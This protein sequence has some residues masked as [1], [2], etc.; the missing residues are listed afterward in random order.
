MAHDPHDP[1]ADPE[2]AAEVEPPPPAG[3]APATFS[4]VL[5]EE[6]ILIGA[7]R[8]V[9]EHVEARSAVPRAGEPNLGG[10]DGRGLDRTTDAPPDED[11]L[12]KAARVRSL[13]SHTAGLAFSGGGIRSATFAVGFL[14][15]LASLG[16]I[17]RF[18]YLST[19]SG[20]GYA[21]SWLAAWLKRE[22]GGPQ[23]VEAQ[24]DP[25][26][27]AQARSHRRLVDGQVVDEEPEPL[28]HLRAFSSYLT[29]NPGLLSTDTW[30]VAL[31]WVR[32]VAV[33]MMMIL[34]WLFGNALFVRLLVY[35][36][37]LYN[38]AEP[39][40]DWLVALVSE[41]MLAAGLVLFF[42]GIWMNARALQEFRSDGAPAAAAAPAGGRWV[43][44]RSPVNA[45]IAVLLLLAAFGVTVPL[46]FVVWRL[47]LWLDARLGAS[48]AGPDGLRPWLQEV[49]GGV[50]LVRDVVLTVFDSVGSHLGLLQWPNLALHVL[51][52]GVLLYVGA[53][54]LAR[55]RSDRGVF[56]RAA[57]AAGATGGVLL[58]LLEVMT[59][60]FARLERPD[61]MATF[62]PPAA[63]LVVVAAIVVEVALLGRAITEAERE[64]WARVSARVAMQAV[65]W[66]VFSAT[67]LYV[68]ALLLHAGSSVRAAIASGWIG[69]AVFGVVTGRYVLPRLQEG[70]GLNITR[71][72]AAA[73]SAVF[74]IGLF[75]AVALA[76]SFLIDSPSP[77]DPR[78]ED[79]SPFALYLA[80][81]R[82]APLWA[83]AAYMVGAGVLWQ[84][85]GA[86]IDANLFSLHAMYANRLTRCYLGASRP[87]SLWARRWGRPRDPRVPTGAPSLSERP[88]APGPPPREPN[89]TT[90]FDLDDDLDLRRLRIGDAGGG[91][92]Y[93]G[94]H[95]LINTTLNLV[96]TA[97]LAWRSRK[98]EP[99]LLSPLYCGSKTV[100]Y[101]QDAGAG[102]NLTL[103]RAVA[104]SGAAVDP[105]MRAYQSASLTAL[106][107]LLNARLGYWIEKPVAQG[108]TAASPRYG[109][110]LQTEMLGLTDSRGKYVHIS[111]GGH[112]ENLGV[113]EL[114]RRRCRYV[115]ALDAGADAGASGENLADLIR[116]VRI[117]FGVRIRLD[118]GALAPEGPD[119]LTR[120]HVVLGRIHYDDVDRGEMPGVFVYVKISLTGDEPPD[121]QR[122]ARSGSGF[123]HQ[124][125]D[126]R[127]SFD[128]EQFESY[129]CLGDHIARDVFRDAAARTEELLREVEIAADR[130]T[131]GE[132][133]PR[134]FSAV[135]GRWAEAPPGQDAHYVEASRAW[136]AL[137]GDLARVP[138]LAALSLDLYPEA[139]PAPDGHPPAPAQPPGPGHAAADGDAERAERHTV[140]RMIDLMEDTWITLGLKR[141]SAVPMNRG[142]MNT[143][144][145]W[146]ATRAFR[147]H[148]PVLRS[149]F[150][151]E[152]VRFCQSQL[153]LAPAKP[154]VVRLA[155]AGGALAADEFVARSLDLLD[156]EFAREWPDEARDRPAAA[157]PRRRLRDLVDRAVALR[158]QRP[159]AWLIVQAPSGPEW[160]SESPE[161]FACGIFLVARFPDHP[162]PP[163]GV[164]PVELFAWVRRGHRSVGLAS[165][166]ARRVV[167]LVE[168]ELRAGGV[169]RPPLWAR[170]PVP[171]A[172]VD[173]LEFAAWLGFFAR[174]DFRPWHPPEG[175]AA[176]GTLLVLD[177]APGAGPVAGQPP[178]AAAPGAGAGAGGEVQ[179]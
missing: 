88:G 4:T 150:S 13:R 137:Q 57:F 90:G 144:R 89:P 34:P 104:V 86:L 48:N 175:V 76:V 74:L 94:P 17:R 151:S 11:E 140:A 1:A 147:R 117:D 100:G 112:F 7:R 38:Q 153:Q 149:E 36:Y 81:V 71:N 20:G 177:A 141:Y 53:A 67:V 116:L 79:A 51:G 93:H 101:A 114:I 143:F 170:F 9:A 58:V 32:N 82:G 95:L 25:S 155:A 45:R 129:R 163:A 176:R 12:V 166:C 55:G 59:R 30:T 21:G 145:R 139:R 6:L 157:G 60:W 5:W 121:L 172:D 97:D 73:A 14:Q 109:S 49:A 128:E 41:L 142:W 152:F 19:V 108:W 70:R 75:G 78:P 146:A 47:G 110:L 115:V 43:R 66:A 35:F 8:E 131:H 33:N 154:D 111:D 122:Y 119:G 68:P 10:T 28:R 92:D 148:W 23:N 167:A 46:R 156:E 61:L 64:W 37:N 106:L 173:D 40:G 162:A 118:T 27:V 85:G 87:S 125:T 102:S 159:L 120:T 130:A 136:S 178:P 65:R 42:L 96:H 124:P 22:G 99:F 135:Q 168:E 15:G 3:P 134:L 50:P 98:G 164:E 63:L 113:Y 174:Y 56:V 161:R 44:A 31:I 105:N 158:P 77:L 127:Q 72:L 62:V 54:W 171:N 39:E 84:L 107:T 91:R 132:Y 24:L 18:D 52:F 69:S 80:G 179:A 103:G 126:L 160:A 83:I 169:P 16:L 165:A 138:E 133:V 29:P 26:R 123:P 2:D